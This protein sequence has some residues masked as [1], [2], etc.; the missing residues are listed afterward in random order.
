MTRILITG[1]NGQLGRE[2]VRAPWASNVEL[3]ALD[4]SRLDVT[5]T[6][7][8][9]SQV[10]SSEPDVIVNAAAYTA[11]DQAESEP[12]LATAV[13]VAGVANLADAAT[14]AGALLIHISSDYVF[15]GTKDGWYIESDP[16]APLGVYG[17]TKAEGEDRARLAP[18]HLILRTAW[19][20]GALGPNFV[21]TM[22]RLGSTHEELRVVND[23]IGCP[24]AAADIASA[25]CRL[26]AEGGKNAPIGTFHLASPESATWYEFAETILADRIESGL[27]LE[28][29]LTSQYPTAAK[30]PANSRLDSSAI[31]EVSG[32]RLPSWHDSVPAVVAELDDR[33]HATDGT[34]E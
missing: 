10:E 34:Q 23:Q 21:A 26:S 27:E 29:I 28:P 9:K 30:R 20:Y 22:R 17:R 31:E 19:V 11:V 24:T 12:E 5:N 1:A 3:T 15:D 18:R 13:N 14:A 33:S 2:L 32:I 4:R 6:W 16:V 25:I 8:V 7:G